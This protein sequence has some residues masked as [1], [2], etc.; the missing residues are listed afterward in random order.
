[1]RSD[2]ISYAERVE[3]GIFEA[4]PA[5]WLTEDELIAQTGINHWNLVR[6]RGKG[7]IVKPI[8]PRLGFA[9][10]TASYYPPIAVPMIRRLD[11]L[12]LASRDADE[13]LWR[14]W[15]EDFPADIRLWVDER[16]AKA[17][18]KL[19][20]IKNDEDL[21]MV[22]AT[23]PPPGR[24][25]PRKLLHKPFRRAA[26]PEKTDHPTSLMIW[27]LA[28][29]TGIDLPATLYDPTPPLFKIL[30]QVGGLPDDGFPLPDDDLHVEQM[31]LDLLRKI[32]AN[33]KDD[34]EFEKAREDWKLISGLAEGTYEVNWNNL[35]GK[36]SRHLRRGLNKTRIPAPPPAV[37][38]LLACWRDYTARAILL[39][40][41]IFVRRS[42]DH[43]RRL[44][45]NLALAAI[46]IS[47][48]RWREGGM[49]RKGANP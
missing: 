27:A 17:Q 44:S 22:A 39:P 31:S 14:L 30:K 37:D 43:S 40:F 34:A 5:G 46:F 25:D 36:V 6:W 9:I 32:L 38:Y 4:K 48:A 3:P 45:Q 20:V 29:A 24:G 47:E 13:W 11:E 8:T 18:Q 42:S 35:R 19:S 15:L 1:M 26:E 12:R 49:A 16:L 2:A 23:L 10:G 41:L 7:L 28:V 21:E 33:V